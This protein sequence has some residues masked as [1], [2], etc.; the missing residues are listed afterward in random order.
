MVYLAFQ[1]TQ[2][3]TGK[4]VPFVFQAA[5]IDPLL[6]ATRVLSFGIMIF[7]ALAVLR[8]WRTHS[9]PVCL[10]PTWS[11]AY[12]RVSCR[13]QYTASSFAKPILK[14]FRSVLSYKVEALRPKG[15]FPA[16]GK[17]SSSVKDASESL[18]FRPLF[19]VIKKFSRKLKWIQSGH[20][21]TYILYILFLLVILLL[22]KLH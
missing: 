6:L 16:A 1:G 10:T 11:C 22:W 15:Y 20:T 3:I 18:F 21:Q 17:L 13:M 19:Y 12:S 7:V 2:A 14:I 8:K 9:Y 4:P 5:V